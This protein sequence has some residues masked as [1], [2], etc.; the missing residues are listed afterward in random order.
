M[1]RV[2]L[3]ILLA[4]CSRG[5]APSAPAPTPTA[6]TQAEERTGRCRDG[7]FT[8]PAPSSVHG[9]L[10]RTLV[11]RTIRAH[12]PELQ[13]CYQ[14]YLE[15]GSDSGRINARF[16]VVADGSVGEA[17]VTGFDDALASCVCEVVATMTFPPVAGA[18]ITIHYPF[19][20]GP[21]S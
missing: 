6:P 17:E 5:P 9:D 14:Q 7:T 20:F 4:G 13:R 3:P 11:Q 21:Q 10:D 8:Q 16:T 1:R 12:T 18:T 15:H 19:T 2:M